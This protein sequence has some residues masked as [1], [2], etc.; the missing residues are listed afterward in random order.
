MLRVYHISLFLRLKMANAFGALSLH[1][2]DDEDQEDLDRDIAYQT[3]KY[4]AEQDLGNEDDGSALQKK[5]WAD[6]DSD[7]PDEPRPKPPP[8]PPPITR[9]LP[10]PPGFKEIVRNKMDKKALAQKP[11]A[12]QR[13]RA[14]LCYCGKPALHDKVKKHGKSVPFGTKICRCELGECR[15]WYA[16]PLPEFP[17]PRNCDCQPPIQAAAFQVKTK[18]RYEGCWF[19]TCSKTN[20]SCNFYARDEPIDS[21]CS[22]P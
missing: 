10:P 6:E 11:K 20:N 21:D 19:Y 7:E 18:T 14:I 13:S 22:S 17:P 8:P 15:F 5:S 4:Q 9:K 3:L 16:I 12:S 1:D 2:D